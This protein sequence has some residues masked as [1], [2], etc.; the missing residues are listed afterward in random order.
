MSPGSEPSPS[1]PEASDPYARLGVSPDAS[2][3]HVQEARQAR[4]AEV[5]EDDPLARS[6]IE[7]AYDAVL[8]DRLKER[9][10][11]RVS[12]AAR[13]A[14]Q[15]EQLA[16]PNDR[17]VLPSLPRLSSLPAARGL[18]SPA[19]LLPRLALASGREFWFPLLAIGGLLVLLLLPHTDPRLPLGLAAILTLFNLQRRLGRFPA[20]V[21]WTLALLV[22]GLLLGGA[23]L[24]LLGPQVPALPLAALQLESVPALLLLLLGAL[25]IA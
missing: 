7:A 16:P 12:T 19:S 8:M 24:A 17:P 23:A 20:A 3:D 22:S 18:P 13:T 6:R 5:G 1:V 9:Q 21:L 15:R 2:F 4:L 25:L 14:S 10:Q 11:G